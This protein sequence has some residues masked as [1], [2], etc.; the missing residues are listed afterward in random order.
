MSHSLDYINTDVNPL[1]LNKL[2]HCW[3]SSCTIFFLL[4]TP[5]LHALWRYGTKKQANG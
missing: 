4:F 2:L 1:F 5:A 3:V